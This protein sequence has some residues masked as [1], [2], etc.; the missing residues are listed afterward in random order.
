MDNNDPKI[1][2]ISLSS[3]KYLSPNGELKVL[4][5][6]Q[7]QQEIQLSEEQLQ[8]LLRLLPRYL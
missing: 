1:D 2:T 5:I 8:S 3:K 4:T 7:G 6:S